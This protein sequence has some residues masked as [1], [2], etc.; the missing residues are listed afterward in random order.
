MTLEKRRAEDGRNVYLFGTG[1]RGFSG[2]AFLT[3]D[4]LYFSFYFFVQTT[5]GIDGDLHDRPNPDQR[6]REGKG[7]T[8]TPIFIRAPFPSSL[9][10]TGHK[11]FAPMLR[12]SLSLPPSL[13]SLVPLAQ[14]FR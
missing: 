13:P 5:K 8:P 9:P 1:N 7:L 12:G 4:R 2:S 3:D 6:E 10:F 14:V 11:F